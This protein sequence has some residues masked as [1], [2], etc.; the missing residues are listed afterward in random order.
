[1]SVATSETQKT[2]ERDRARDVHHAIEKAF[3]RQAED[4]A[5][6]VYVTVDGSTVFLRGSVRSFIEH[7][8]ALQAAR[9]VDGVE[10]IRDTI[11]V[12][13]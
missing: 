3:E 5:R 10:N 4:D 9:S 6:R 1:M 12:I 7:Q 13:P 11:R 8:D 2:E